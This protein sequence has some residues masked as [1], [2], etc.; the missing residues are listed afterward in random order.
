MLFA[1]VHAIKLEITCTCSTSIPTILLVCFLSS[2]FQNKWKLHANLFFSE[3]FW[4]YVYRNEYNT[5]V[6]VPCI[7]TEYYSVI[8]TTF[9]WFSYYWLSFTLWHIKPLY[10][11][12]LNFKI[13]ILHILTVE[14]WNIH[15]KNVTFLDSFLYTLCILCIFSSMYVEMYVHCT[16]SCNIRER[17]W[18]EIL[19]KRFFHNLCSTTTILCKMKLISQ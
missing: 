18:I 12:I 6:E 13:F 16:V 7:L 3:M 4:G 19:C 5:D 9:L 2:P 15:K 10:G 17:F 1:Q 8:Y 14:L 11:C